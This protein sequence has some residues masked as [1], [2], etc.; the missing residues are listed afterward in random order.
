[1][2]KHGASLRV[3]S[4]LASAL[5]FVALLPA[6]ARAASGT[7]FLYEAGSTNQVYGFSVNSA[8]GELNPIPGS[9]FTTRLDATALAVDPQGQFLF[10]ANNTDNDVSVFTINQNTGAITEVANSPFD[11]GTGTNP[12]ALTTDPSGSF[13]FVTNELSLTTTLGVDGGTAYQGDIDVYEIDRTTGELTPSPNSQSPA[14]AMQCA[15]N[16]VGVVAVPQ[17]QWLYVEAGFG[18]GLNGDNQDGLEMQIDQFQYNPTTGDLS[19]INSLTDTTTYAR[20]FA[21]DQL[22]AYVMAGFGQLDAFL[23]PAIIDPVTG[24]ISAVNTTERSA[25]T[26]GAASSIQIDSTNNFVF[27]SIGEFSVNLAPTGGSPEVA[28]IGSQAGVNYIGVTDR[29]APFFYSLSGASSNELTGFQIDPT[30]GALTQ[31]P[32]STYATA[33]E[34]YAITGYP[35]VA[36]APVAAFSPAALN[37]GVLVVGTPSTEPLTLYNTGNQPLTISAKSISGTNAADFSETDNCPASLAAGAN[38]TFNITF[39]ASANQ[40]F[41]AQLNVT[42]NAAAS[43]QA[44]PLSGTGGTPTPAIT[45]AP[46]SLTFPSTTVGDTSS[47]L[48]VTLTNTGTAALAITTVALGGPNPG[49]FTTTGCS[50]TTLAVSATCTI[51]VSFEPQ[52]VGQRTANI[53]VTD[54]AANSPQTI[55]IV[56]TGA[57]PFTLAAATGSSSSTTISAGQTAQFSL[58]L[59]STDASFTGN[60]A[61]TCSGAPSGDSCTV[62]PTSIDVTSTGSSSVTVSVGPSSSVT[63]ANPNQKTGWRYPRPLVLLLASLSMILG[64]MLLTARTTGERFASRLAKPAYAALAL[65]LVAILGMSACVGSGTGGSGSS[66]SGSTTYTLTVTATSGNVSVPTTLTLTVKN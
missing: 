19:L 16:P 18:N 31:V 15:I 29:I 30:T 20:G 33:G 24:N 42:N 35:T 43:P 64:V 22:G 63:P 56:A 52:A 37:F 54:N 62:S 34:A 17:G 66:Q 5:F 53:T 11:A 36:Q 32:G 23:Q 1:M 2:F 21:G 12:T 65:A 57:A 6:A 26:G 3:L 9:P 61:I 49:D 60:V 10:V 27:A 47:A 41:S 44:V 4:I 13:L 45:L 40:A 8:T 58:S 51:S 14:T 7:Q 48:A 39:T 28:P 59:T 50:A 46:T 55:S 38:C 25:G